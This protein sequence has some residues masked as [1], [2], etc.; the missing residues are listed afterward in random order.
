[1]KINKELI[2]QLSTEIMTVNDLDE[3]IEIIEEFLEM[4]QSIRKNLN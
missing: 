3:K 1:M 2:E 4:Y